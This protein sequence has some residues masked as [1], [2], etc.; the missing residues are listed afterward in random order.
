MKNLTKTNNEVR[1]NEVINALW[2]KVFADNLSRSASNYLSYIYNKS[3]TSIDSSIINA[4][5]GAC[6]DLM[7]DD[8]SNIPNYLKRM[9]ICNANELENWLDFLK[10]GELLS[11]EDVELLMYDYRSIVG[12]PEP[13]PYFPLGDDF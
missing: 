3:D 1:T 6:S 11:D 12:E 10:D 2:L 8:R 9:Y 4:V 7:A 13:E 5:I